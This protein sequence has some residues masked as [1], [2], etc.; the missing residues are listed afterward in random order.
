M[1]APDPQSPRDQ[2]RER[3]R[4]MVAD[5]EATGMTLYKI[6]LCLGHYY[7][8]VKNW[9]TTGRLES[10]DAKALEALHREHCGPLVCQLEPQFGKTYTMKS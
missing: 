7:T 6:A 2:D 3:Y 5:L 1:N 8:T 10:S 4:Q 9:K